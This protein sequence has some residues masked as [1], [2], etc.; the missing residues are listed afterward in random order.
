MTAASSLAAATPEITIQPFTP[1]HIPGAL[2]LSQEC[3]WPHRAEDWALTLGVSRGVVALEGE[4]VVGTAIC[5][6]FGTA[7]TVNMIIVAERMRGC[8]LGR[9]LMQAVLNLGAGHELRLVATA[10]GL[11]LYEKLG[12]V[13]TGQIL[14]HQGIARA[15]DPRRDIRQGTVADLD[16]FAAADLAASGLERAALLARI[17]AEGEMLVTEGGFAL[18]RPFGRGHVVGPVV[19]RDLP[20]ARALIAA[21]A[22][23]CEGRFLRIDLPETAGLSDYAESLG[24]AHAGGGVSMV[25]DARS[26]TDADFTTYALVSQALG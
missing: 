7:A 6:A 1:A 2:R 21:A 23:K 20:T 14:Q 15:S 17:E 9:R 25:R 8:G 10:D 4:T 26:R 13:A 16:A 5:S 12:F 3:A 18:L 22:T 19:A 11:P 24:L